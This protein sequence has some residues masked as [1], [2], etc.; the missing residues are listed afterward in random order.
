MSKP[1]NPISIAARID[2]PLPLPIS[3]A[4]AIGNDK[5]IISIK[6]ISY[7]FESPVGFSNG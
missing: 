4:Y 2:N 1:P 5:G 3:L 7:K 6:N